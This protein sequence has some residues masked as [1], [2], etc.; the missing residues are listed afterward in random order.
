MNKLVLPLIALSCLYSIAVSAAAAESAA[1]P[2]ADDRDRA[3]ATLRREL[4][5]QT[6]FVKVHA[7]E[8]L[9]SLSYTK[10][11][12]DAFL[13]ELEQHGGEPHYRTGVFRT[14]ARAESRPETRRE[15]VDR[16]REIYFN[17]ASPDRVHVLEGLAKIGYVVPKKDRASFRKAVPPDAA[18]ETCLRWLFA[19]SGALED[20]RFLAELLDRDDAATRGLAAYELRHLHKSLPDDVVQHLM[21]HAATESQEPARVHLLCAAFVAAPDPERADEFKKLLLPYAESGTPKEKFQLT[22]AL[23]ERGSRDDV[24]LARRLMS[25]SDPDVRIGAAYALLRIDRRRS[26]HFSILDWLVLAGYGIGMMAI[27]WYYSRAKNVEEYLLGGRKMKP[28]AVGISLY[29]TLMSTLTY[30]ALP[31]E[32]ISH[33]PL[34]LGGVCSY[35]FVYLIVT[36]YMMP[37]IIKLRVTSAYEILEQR[38]GLSVRMLGSTLFL[39]LRLLWMSLIVYATSS[40]ILVPLLH[41]DPS[42]TPWVCIVMAVVT[43]TYTSMGGLQAV[44]FTDVVQTFIMLLG[45]LLSLGLITYSLGGLSAWWPTEWQ[46]TWDRPSLFDPSA[47]IPWGMALLSQFTWYICTTG[48]DQMA[49]QRYLATR[50]VPSARRM[51]GISLI[52]EVFVVLLLAAL[53]LALFAFFHTYPS[54]LPDGA[55]LRDDTDQ[56]LPQYI[57]RVLPAGISGL[58]IAG[59]LSAAMDS[60]SSGLNSACSVITVDWI[61][62]FRRTQLHGKAHVREARIVSWSV[63]IAVITLSLF[64]GLVPGNLLE[65]CYTVVNLL[66]TPLFILF[67]MAMFVRWATTPGTWIGSLAALATAIAIAYGGLFGLSF[68]WMM[69]A[70]A[71]VG[72][73]VG[74]LASLLPLGSPRPML[75]VAQP[76][77]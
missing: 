12:L 60:L 68:I 4:T 30:L 15:H 7:A 36:R 19:N 63:G 54:M 27:G 9:L 34:F 58:V 20:V 76:T 13:T 35:P 21:S 45:A 11:V 38:F 33:G 37:A 51:L 2:T 14:L 10:E 72:V 24:D 5:E 23:A 50:D 42:A 71:V 77:T 3:L 55:N 62:R 28:W 61:D 39:S 52:L 8:S 32:M 22:L 49:I 57:V 18:G 6:Q 66:V 65:K 67:F 17:P 56:L 64:A 41:L 59:L 73:L 47:R 74:C 16:L 44:V 53:G 26:L 25:D 31:G 1:W 40:K 75:Q 70:S 48:S 69:P 43:I 29:A 46:P